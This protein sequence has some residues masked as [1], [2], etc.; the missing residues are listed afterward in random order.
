M[1]GCI[2]LEV[3]AWGEG[4][5]S[6]SLDYLRIDGDPTLPPPGGIWRELDAALSRRYQ[7]PVL[8]DLPVRAACVDTG[9]ATNNAYAFVRPRQKRRVWAVKGRDDQ[10]QPIWPDKVKSRNRGGV[11]LRSINTGQAKEDIFHR[12]R[13]RTPGPGFC[14]FPVGRDAAYFE[15]LTAETQRITYRNGRGKRQWVV[16]EGAR[17]EA[18]D[19]RVYAYAA[20]L[21]LVRQRVVALK[22]PT[23]K[24]TM[25][26]TAAPPLDTTPEQRDAAAAPRAPRRTTPAPP[27]KRR[28]A[29]HWSEVLDW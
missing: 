9:A 13:V 17:N 5:E 16:R 7:H 26:P 22:A 12:L 19:V 14:H 4:Y 10:G 11:D 20:L 2:V 24:A 8:G 23:S 3:V 21:G 29:S 25:E 6:W 27:A 18:L 15:E 1:R 28:R